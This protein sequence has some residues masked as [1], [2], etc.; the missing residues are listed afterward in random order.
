MPA[1]ISVRWPTKRRMRS[2]MRLKAC[3]RLAHLA[4]A[5]RLHRP[6]IAAEPEGLRRPGQPAD[7]PHLVLH[8]Q[9]GDAREDQRRAHQPDDEQIERR[10]EQPLARRLHMQ[11]AVRQLHPDDDAARIALPVG[12][13]GQPYAFPQRV[14][15]VLLQRQ[16]RQAGR[17]G[18]ELD[19]GVLLVGQGEV[20]PPGGLAEDP[21]AVL[22][23]LPPHQLDQHR[24]V[25]GDAARQPAGDDVEMRAVEQLQRH[26]L[27]DQHRHQDDQDGPRQQPA[28]QQRPQRAGDRL[29]RRGG[30]G[31]SP[32]PLKIR[33]LMVRAAARSRGGARCAG[34]AARAG[35]ARS[36]GAGG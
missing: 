21:G 5:L 7:R 27:Q 25:A 12:V 10:G 19:A 30:Q 36:C 20:E 4:G 3:R 11:H 15:Q 14:V 34:S 2:C 18:D 31:Q 23:R 6:D 26:R 8:E 29:G 32:P 35:R 13:E 16:Q 24:H 17:A 33:A 9:D 1:S 28:R 22:R